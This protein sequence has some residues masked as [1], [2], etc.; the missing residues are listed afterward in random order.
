M[1]DKKPRSR[2]GLL[3]AA[4]C[5]SVT[6]VIWAWLAFSP[7]TKEDTSQFT[8]H[9]IVMAVCVF[10]AVMNWIRYARFYR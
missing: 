9:L 2:G 8:L 1:K 6:A 10:S 5:W 3:F 4:I 7:S